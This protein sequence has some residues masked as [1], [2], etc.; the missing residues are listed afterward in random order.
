MLKALK[1]A[2]TKYTVMSIV[3][4]ITL[5]MAIFWEP[6]EKMSNIVNIVG[7]AFFTSTALTTVF[8][9]VFIYRRITSSISVT[10]HTHRY[11]KII[12][13]A[14]ESSALYSVAA[15]LNA[16]CI[17]I[18][19]TGLGSISAYSFSQYAAACTFVMTVSMI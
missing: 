5:A 17:I 9:T 15:L 1:L 7:A 14:I 3:S 4:I 10:Q 11:T 12:H 6:T 8:S 19:I 13:F 18:N 16:I 2:L